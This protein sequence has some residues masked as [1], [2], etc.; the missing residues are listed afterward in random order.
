[1]AVELPMEPSR[2]EIDLS[3]MFALIYGE[4]KIGKSTLASTFPDALFIATEEGLRFLEVM[5]IS[6]PTWIQFREIVKALKEEEKYKTRYKTIVI[7]TVDLLYQACENHVCEAKGIS[8]PSD[9]DWGRG[10]A[11]VREEFH[12]GMRYLA[13]EGYG[14]VFISHTRSIERNVRGQKVPTI[15]PSFSNQ[16]RKVIM[17][18]VD[19]VFYLSM[20]IDNPESNIRRVY[21]QNTLQF[22]CGTRQ[23]YFAEAIDEVSYDGIQEALIEARQIEEEMKN[24]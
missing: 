8:H 22:E 17:P 5:K 23:K 11:M 20:D 6:C 9:D 1:M 4:P 19:F 7:D 16:A 21:S 3:K 14:V 13:A 24:G 18:L 15:V 12:K 2:P 10:W